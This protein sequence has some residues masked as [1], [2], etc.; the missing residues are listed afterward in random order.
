M[1]DNTTN[2][3][4]MTNER[5]YDMIEKLRED[6]QQTRKVIIKYNGLRET[7]GELK[8]EVSSLRKWKHEHYGEKEGKKDLSYW[9]QWAIL[10]LLSLS[11]IAQTIDF[12]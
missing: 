5:L 8:R 10:I 9:L 1:A 3:G 4:F 12:L 11:Q 6:L 2:D 7:Q